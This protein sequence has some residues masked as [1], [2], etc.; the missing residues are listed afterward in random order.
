[1]NLKLYDVLSCGPVFRMNV[2]DI[3]D[4][5]R[6]SVKSYKIRKS[7]IHTI[8]LSFYNYFGKILK[9]GR[10][11]RGKQWNTEENVYREK[12]RGFRKRTVGHKREIIYCN[13]TKWLRKICRPN[14]LKIQPCMSATRPIMMQKVN[15]HVYQVIQMNVILEQCVLWQTDSWTITFSWKIK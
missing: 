14:S 9:R 3:F 8:D 15:L 6:P 4:V 10:N 1:M 5:I 11:A 13:K 7:F 2:S 12:K